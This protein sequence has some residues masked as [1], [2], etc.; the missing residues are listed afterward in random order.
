MELYNI[1]LEQAILGTV[2]INNMYFDRALA[3]ITKADH[4]Y[5][6]ANRVIWER[7]EE[8]IMQGVTD[9]VILKTFFQNNEVIKQVGG[10]SYLATLLSRATGVID[11]RDYAREVRELWQKRQ[12]LALIEKS[13]TELGDKSFDFVAGNLENEM[14]GLMTNNRKKKTKEAKEIIKQIKDDR[15]I[16]LSSK[17]IPT[18]FKELDKVLNGGIRSKYCVVIGGRAGIGKTTI[19]QNIIL[20]NAKA[21][22]T[23]LFI[24]MEM[25]EEEV[26]FKFCSNLTS[27]SS[28]KLQDGYLD[29]SEQISR[30][31]AERELEEMRIFINDS[32]TLRI[33][34]INR[35]IKMQLEKTPVDMVFI[36]Y[37]QIIRGDDAKGKNEAQIIKENTTALAGMAKQYDVAIVALAQINRNGVEAPKIQDLKGSGGIEEDAHIVILIHRDVEKGQFLNS[38]SLIVAKN[39]RGRTCEIPICFDGEFG[40]FAEDL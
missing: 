21:G 20:S 17:V 38:G 3:D 31:R 5:E 2:I 9:G 15:R 32:P 24:S 37:I 35:I 33:G 12:L 6:P 34:E 18:G 13:M 11:I 36:D 19:A 7:I 25:T 27:I 39:R 30:D 4:F 40:R 29:Q 8:I 16:G 26:I 14:L 1:E 22:K 23:C 28:A 10:A